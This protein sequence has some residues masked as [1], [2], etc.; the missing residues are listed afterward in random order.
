[1]TDVGV[2]CRWQ[3]VEDGAPREGVDRWLRHDTAGAEFVLVAM[4][5]R[6]PLTHHVMR[7]H[8]VVRAYQAS[9]DITLTVE[10]Y[11]PG[12]DGA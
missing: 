8:A 12:D 2:V 7:A 3:T 9:G 6:H 4:P 1:M 11:D 5:V 10:P